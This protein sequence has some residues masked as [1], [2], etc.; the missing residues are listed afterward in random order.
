MKTRL[1]IDISQ[2]VQFGTNAPNDRRS[3]NWI[4]FV[5]QELQR[6]FCS[7]CHRL[8]HEHQD[9]IE[10]YLL[11]HQDFLPQAPPQPLQALGPFIEP[12]Y[13]EEYYQEML[14][15][16]Y[17]GHPDPE[18]SDWGSNP[19]GSPDSSEQNKSDISFF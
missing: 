6:L 18:W 7:Y 5:Y 3:I 8:G 19:F 13:D 9:C 4:D 17:F 1:K 2:P 11:N 14:H 16:A 12:E 10:I 15:N